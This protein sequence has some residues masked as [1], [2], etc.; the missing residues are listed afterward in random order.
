[1]SRWE[2]TS[3]GV[4]A[5]L[6]LGVQGEAKQLLLRLGDEGWEAFAVT[7]PTPPTGLGDDPDESQ[8]EVLLKR[9]LPKNGS[10]ARW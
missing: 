10:A 4:D 3:V 8:Y 9:P 5:W 7:P 1:M 6:P 2:Y